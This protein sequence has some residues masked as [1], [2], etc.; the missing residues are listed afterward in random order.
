MY[1]IIVPTFNRS[2]LLA[3]TLESLLVQE[4]D[5]PY[6]IIVVDNNSPDDT[7]GVVRAMGARVA[8]NVRY[9]FEEKQGASAARNAGVVAARG[10]ILVFVDDDVIASPHWLSALVLT[11]RRYTNAW[12]VGGKITLRLPSTCPRWFDPM[13]PVLTGQLSLLDYGDGTV[14][15]NYPKTLTSANL[16]VR[17]EVL[18]REGVFD[19]RLG[20]AGSALLGGEDQDLCYR[21]HRSGGAVYYC[22]TATVAHVIPAS[23]LTKRY[24]RRK[25]YGHGRATAVV[26]PAQDE[27]REVLSLGSKVMKDWAKALGHYAVGDVSR[28]FDHEVTSWLWLGRLRE[29]LRVAKGNRNLLATA[30]ALRSEDSAGGG[31]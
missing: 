10:E 4:T 14:R 7:A 2:G 31:A 25:A 17:R 12:C 21:V 11:Y 15:V 29:S 23:R 26:L 24:F 3:G 13:S 1:S 30:P 16:S 22:G 5:V 19:T 9:V 27:W 28:G 6:E 18:S 20:H 8:A